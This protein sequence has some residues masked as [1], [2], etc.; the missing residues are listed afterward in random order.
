MSNLTM[1][2]GGEGRPSRYAPLHKKCAQP[3]SSILI[4]HT[5][6]DKNVKRVKMVY[7]NEKND[8]CIGKPNLITTQIF[9]L[10]PHSL[11]SSHPT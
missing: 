6:L 9:V 1:L 5:T 8:W 7:F 10:P 4:L 2:A 11:S 3:R